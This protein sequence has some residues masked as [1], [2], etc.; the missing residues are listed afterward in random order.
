MISKSARSRKSSQVGLGKR[1]TQHA[2]AVGDAADVQPAAAQAPQQ[3]VDLVE[4]LDRGRRIV[5]GRRERPNGNVHEQADRVLGILQRCALLAE[6]DPFQHRAWVQLL[7]CTVDTG[8]R[9]AICHQVADGIFHLDQG[10]GFAGSLDETVRI[11]CRNDARRPVVDDLLRG[12]RRTGHLVLVLYC[13][14]AI[15]RHVH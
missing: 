1:S 8:D 2:G 6:Y 3:I 11:E 15:G 7:L 9:Q 5:D 4:S 13:H 10:A 12:I 14:H